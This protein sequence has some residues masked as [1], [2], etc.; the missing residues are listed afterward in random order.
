MKQ[1]NFQGPQSKYSRMTELEK[2]NLKD[3]IFKSIRMY[4][5]RKRRMRLFIGSAAVMVLVIGLANHYFLPVPQEQSIA[6]FVQSSKKLNPTVTD[7]IVLFL[8]EGDGVK[9]DEEITEV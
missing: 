6:D 2:G 4:N 3:G 5:T 9:I 7:K 1:N 8:G